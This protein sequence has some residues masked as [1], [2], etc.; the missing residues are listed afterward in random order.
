MQPLSLAYLHI[1]LGIAIVFA[2]AQYPLFTPS[3]WLISIGMMVLSFLLLFVVIAM[4]PGPLKLIAFV[5]FAVV[6]GQALSATVADAKLKGVLF[7]VLVTVI[8]VAAVFT[9]LAFFDT[10]NRFLG[11]G[12]YLF[13]ALLGLVLARLV[14]VGFVIAGKGDAVENVSDILSWFA[15]GLFA[16]YLAYD[17]QMMKKRIAYANS[18]GKKHDY[19]DYALGPYLD[20]LNLF[21]AVEDLSS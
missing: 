3:N 21:V 9:A 10:Q 19:V 7:D 12:T 6:I 11:F 16:V 4:A 20:I 14:V 8:T 15:S 1:V 2:S 13:V 5:L 18:K 17:T